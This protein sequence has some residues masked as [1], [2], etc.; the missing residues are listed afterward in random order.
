MEQVREELEKDKQNKLEKKIHNE[1]ENQKDKPKKDSNQ[2]FNLNKIQEEIQDF[3]IGLKKLYEIT[4][5]NDVNEI[6]Q[7]FI[8]QDETEQSLEDTKNDYMNRLQSLNN[9]K[10]NLKKTI[11]NLKFGLT[12][13][14][15]NHDIE[16]KENLIGQLNVKLER[17]S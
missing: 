15:K 13:H 1:T 12:I 7:K 11:E 8:T 9:Q 17:Y 3:E 10:T 2:T 6:I 16:N 4:G 14:V 5:V